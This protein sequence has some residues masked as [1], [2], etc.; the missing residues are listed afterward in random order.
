MATTGNEGSADG[1]VA[2][3]A[4]PAGAADTLR[5]VVVLLTSLLAIA[6]AFLGS[7]AFIG[8]PI[9]DAA[10]GWLDADSTLLAPARPAFAI[11]SVIYAGLFAYALWQLLPAQRAAPRHRRVGYGVALSLVLNALWIGVVQLGLL[12]AS[13]AVIAV[14][15]ALLGWIFLQLRRMPARSALDGIITDGSIGLYLGWV[16]VATAAN[17]TAVLAA[18]GFDGGPFEPI[19]WAVIVIAVAGGI[20]VAIGLAGRGRLAPMVSLCWGLA[21]IG[22][23]RLTDEPASRITGIAALIAAGVVAVVTIGARIG[24]IVME[25]ADRQD[26]LR[27]EAAATA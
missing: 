21:W 26:R 13:L 25:R 20:G 9:Q 14:L 11:W 22:V 2:T 18:A 27:Q 1:S 4:R 8:T 12:G 23:A 16:V 3:A 24:T 6:G 5:Q 17:A 7:G 10:G 19:V 15:A